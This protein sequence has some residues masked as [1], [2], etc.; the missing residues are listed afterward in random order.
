MEAVK[1]N[2]KIQAAYLFGSYAKQTENKWSDIDIALVSE[3]FSKDLFDARVNLL[4]LAARI[5]DRI[6]PIPYNRENFNQD[7]PLVHEIR[8]NGIPIA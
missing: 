4:R 3:D 6:E 7:D 8:K 5:D 1:K 2:Y